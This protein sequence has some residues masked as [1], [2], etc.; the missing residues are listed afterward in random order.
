MWMNSP[1]LRAEMAGSEVRGDDSVNFWGS[2]NTICPF[3]QRESE[4]RITCE[5]IS[6]GT[7]LSLGFSS[8][9]EKLSW[10]ERYCC[11]FEY[12]HCPISKVIQKKYRDDE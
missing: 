9:R 4:Y 5:G 12:E 3:Y 7:V 8:C 6:D 1:K 10:Q 11:Q 2:A